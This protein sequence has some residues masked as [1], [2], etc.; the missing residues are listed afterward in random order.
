MLTLSS[1]IYCHKYT[2]KN[3]AT[4]DTKISALKLASLDTK[5][6]ETLAR[7]VTKSFE[8]GVFPQSLKL[9]RVVPV[10]KGGSKT[11]TSNYRPISLLTS[12]SK[13]YEKLMHNRIV[14][15]MNSNNSFYEMQYGFRAGRSCEHAVLK[16]QSILLESLNKKQISLLLLIDF[17]KAFDMVEH[18]ILLEKLQHYGIRGTALSWL[19]SYLENREQFVSVGGKN[20]SKTSI[21]YGVP[22]G[23]I[24]GP[25]LFVIYIN[26]MPGIANFAKFILYVDDAN[27]IVTGHNLLEIEE[28][29][30]RLS[31]LLLKWVNDN[32]LLL[33]LRKT[34]YMIFT[35]QNIQQNV[36]VM[37]GN[38]AIERKSETKFLG[39]II[40]DRLTWTQHI[41][42][43]K[44][45]MSRYVGIMYKIKSQLPLQA[46]IQIY[47]SFVQSHVNYCSLVWGFA[48]KSNI[49]SLFTSQKKGIRA[50]MPGFVQ[51]YYKDGILPAHTKVSFN[52]YKILTVHNVIAKNTMVFMH[53]INYFPDMLPNSIK[54]TIAPDAPVRGSNHETCQDWLSIFGTCV[55]N[56]SIFFKGPLLYVDPLTEQFFTP[57]A[58][59]SINH[60]KSG[61]K[62]MLLNTQATG[63]TE[64]WQSG[65]FLLLNINGLRRSSRI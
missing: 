1:Q 21:T 46:R 20:S 42:A 34:N 45:K 44:M 57:S 33:N 38:T 53:K 35:R 27:I 50:V 52:K 64:E 65:N 54:E 26:D 19:K 3:K 29:L 28:K 40:D 62:R 16:A 18:S 24:L 25:L 23:S 36:N 61:T 32:G 59:L 63:N 2:V 55:Y 47:H 5:F 51:S 22:Q 15:F 14:D 49:E 58:L 30:S 37:I 13:I 10:H 7:V 48:A 43:I 12:F 6:V 39:V 4:L 60:F 31:I 11:E 56:K 41:R 17:S 9:A 8:D